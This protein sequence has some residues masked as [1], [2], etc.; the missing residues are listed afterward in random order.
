MNSKALITQLT[1]EE[2][3][4]L[5]SG[6][7]FWHLKGIPRLEIPSVMVADGPHGLRKQPGNPTEISMAETIPAT[8]F[9]TASSLAATW[10]RELI[11]QV[12]Q[13]LAEE[14]REEQVS[15]LL[16]PGANIKRSPLCGRNF[17]YFSEDPYLSGEMAKSH[18]NGVQSQG[19]G[20]SLKHYAVNNQE[21]RRMTIDAVVD[22][23]ALREIYLA[24]FEIAVRD[25]QPW[26]VMGAYNKVTGTYA[27]EH[28]DLLTKILQGEWG[29]RGLAITDWGA[30]NDR[31]EA[32]KAGLAIEMPGPSPGNDAQIVAAV[33]QGRLDESVLDR[34][35]EKILELIHKSKESLVDDFQYDREAHHELARRAAGEGAV[36]LK[37]QDR[38]LPLAGETRI[39]LIGEMAR[40]PRFQGAGSS[41]VNPLRVENILEEMTRL[42]GKGQ[43]EFVPGYQLESEQI[44]PTLVQEALTA[45]K[46]ADVLV[47]CAGLPGSFEVEGLDREHIRLP[48]NQNHLIATLAAEHDKVVVVLSNGAPVEM[49]WIDQVQAVLEGYLGG[50]AGGSALVKILSGEIN[51]SGKLAETFPIQLE[52]TPCFQH[53][54][55]GPRMVEY[56]ESLYV[57]YR[58]YDSVEKDVLFPFG[59]GL[60]YT[61]FEY[62]DLKLTSSEIT[63]SD[64]LEVSLTV[65]NSGDRAGK[66]IVQLYIKP[67]DPAPFRPEK[68]LKGFAKIDLAP[69]E[70][71][72]VSFVLDRRSFAYYSA[73]HKDWQVETGEYQ[74]LVGASSRDIRCQAEVQVKSNQQDLVV[75][76]QDR[77]PAYFDFPPDADI[78]R[79]DFERLLGSRV[80]DNQL[81]KKGAYTVNTPLSEMRGSLAGRLLMGYLNRQVD[82][83]VQDDRHSPHAL[84]VRS[85]VKEMPLRSLALMAGRSLEPELL[86]GI[87]IMVNGRFL[88]GLVIALR[89]IRRAG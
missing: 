29:H 18:I 43:I 67:V 57:G 37:N 25:A 78:S 55:G 47:I 35:V 22:E 3:A 21:Y 45:A 4:S 58:F 51:P 80:P 64:T 39:A 20:A 49:P 40:T 36:L 54:P 50:Q 81:I 56:R 9:P 71:G 23:R 72:V 62:G 30:M 82:K 77:Q 84:M 5:C 32:L 33:Q 60:S 14:C 12:G 61:T 48:R 26:T 86:D 70:E 7:D 11:Y 79:E 24:G 41:E 38:V 53:F 44:D 63:E 85:V 74:V 46:N 75:P 2:K 76:D 17:E 89:A 73:G 15:V 19:I 8:C 34:M 31:V 69:G 87:L 16:G 88:K 13:A 52:D 27:C 68:E 66:E 83:V 65:K 1:L 6:Q 42:S 28:P 10:N 59:H